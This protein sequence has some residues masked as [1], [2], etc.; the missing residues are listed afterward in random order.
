MK[1]MENGH[2][3]EV[4]ESRKDLGFTSCCGPER[5]SKQDEIKHFHSLTGF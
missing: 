2:Q 4:E 3:E 1:E 5:N